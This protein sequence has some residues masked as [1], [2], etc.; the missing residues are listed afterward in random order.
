M[1]NN[2][3]ENPI[4]TFTNWFC[5]KISPLFYVM[6]FTPDIISILA[7]VTGMLA[8]WLLINTAMHDLD[9]HCADRN[10]ICTQLSGLAICAQVQH[11]I[12]FW[13]LP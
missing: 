2:H 10:F 1:K 11:G 13:R 5:D 3:T 6:G 7:F 4:D 12:D 8:V 9:E